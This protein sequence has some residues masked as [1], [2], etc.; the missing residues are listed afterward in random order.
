MSL[1]IDALLSHAR[2]QL[3]R[4]ILGIEKVPTYGPLL[5]A[6]DAEALLWAKQAASS[7][8][9]HLRQQKL[10]VSTGQSINDS[11]AAA[12]TVEASKTST[13]NSSRGSGKSSSVPRPALKK[14][15]ASSGKPSSNV[16][17]ITSTRRIIIYLQSLLLAVP[18]KDR[19]VVDE[20]SK[21][22]SEEWNK[23]DSI[24]ILQMTRYSG[25]I[26]RK[27]RCDALLSLCNVIVQAVTKSGSS[28]GSRRGV[29]SS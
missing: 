5:A 20:S 15:T 9:R 13:N 16:L 28:G 8:R 3:G 12:T 22:L 10:A 11:A 19:S 17:D 21:A 4:V 25:W 7:E 1:V 27:S 23:Y 6:M 29:S 26:E 18:V 14:V 24:P 2:L